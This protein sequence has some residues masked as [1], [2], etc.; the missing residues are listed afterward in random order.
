MRTA[1]L[2]F[3]FKHPLAPDA[4]EEPVNV[5]FGYPRYVSRF[6]F[7]G[8]H[9]PILIFLK[10]RPANRFESYVRRAHVPRFCVRNPLLIFHRDLKRTWLCDKGRTRTCIRKSRPG[11]LSRAECSSWY[12]G[13]LL[14]STNSATLSFLKKPGD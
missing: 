10:A 2:T 3:S 6:P 7:S 5:P 13:Y 12:Y 9:E 4:L 1:L 11:L 14:A 8:H